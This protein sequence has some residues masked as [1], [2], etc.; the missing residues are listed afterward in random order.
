[1]TIRTV[2]ATAA[3][4][5]GLLAVAVAP[6]M[7]ADKKPAAPPAPVI[8][9]VK[10][11]PLNLAMQAAQVAL[12]ECRKNNRHPSVGVMDFD[13][14]M[15]VLLLDDGAGEVGQHALVHKMYTSLLLQQTTWPMIAR[16]EPMYHIRAEI[17]PEADVL[18]KIAPGGLVSPGGYA[19]KIGDQF[20]GVIGAGGTAQGYGPG[21]EAKCAEAGGDWF[22]SVVNG[23]PFVTDPA[24]PAYKP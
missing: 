1:M 4:A 8:P 9:W 12:D 15:K 3:C 5:A 17:D 11:I 22:E 24:N 18:D 2:L 6:S 21:S 23:K 20:V 10:S 14:N 7:A 16:A 13:G 19:L